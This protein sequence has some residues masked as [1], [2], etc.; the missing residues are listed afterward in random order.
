MERACRAFV[1]WFTTRFD[2]SRKIGIVCGTGNNG[3]DGLGIARLLND[4]GYVV[5][6]WIVRG[7]V[8]ETDDFK[9]NL[10][11]LIGKVKIDEISSSS[12]QGLFVNLN[13]L[14][15]AVFGSGLSRPLEGIYSQV[16]N[17]INQADV[18]RIAIDIPSGLM[19][20][21]HREGEAVKADYTLSFQLP[22]LAFFLPENSDYTGEWH[23][24][25]IGLNSEFIEQ[26]DTSSFF[27]EQRDIKLII[28]KR[29]KFSHKGTYGKALLVSGSYGR[30]GAAVLASRAAMRS[31]LGL[32][33]TH[34]PKCGYVIMQT[35]VPEAMVSIDRHE[36]LF[37]K[38]PRL[39]DYDAI[40][41][42]P[43]IGTE[44]ETVSA[45]T[46]LVEQAQKPMVIDADGLNILSVHRELF[47]LIPPNSILTPHPKEFERLAGSW[48]DDFD[49]LEKQ[50]QFAIKT[51]TIILLKGAYSSIA[52]P[53]GKI[54]FNPTGNPGMATGGSGDVLTGLLT[55]LLAQQY[56]SEEAALLGV[57]LHGLSGDFAAGNIGMN[58]MIA[59]DIVKSLPDAF[60]SFHS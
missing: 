46:S 34:I 4:L 51:K 29:Q 59:S 8:V 35:S 28:K 33:T 17:C 12:D 48:K 50:K 7:S 25:N 42:G 3:G 9:K 10:E 41:I 40:G 57:Y 21:K 2:T 45:F 53:D 44:N 49:R 23:I 58:A 14:I 26:A 36:T 43:G 60:K 19:A 39:D 15:D 52:T 11:R 54:H 24:V 1:S 38:P 55:G 16:V 13:I 31:G 5:Q 47:H 22:K 18:N 6:V 30:M 37:S 27:I 32:L 20:N 56:T